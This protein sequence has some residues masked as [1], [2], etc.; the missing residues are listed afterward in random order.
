[1]SGD[2][3]MAARLDG[4]VDGFAGRLEVIEGPTGRSTAETARI[5]AE[6]LLPGALVTEVAR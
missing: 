4:L 5:A 1:M 6:S 2:G 3:K